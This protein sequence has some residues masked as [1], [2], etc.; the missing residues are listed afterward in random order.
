MNDNKFDDYVKR[1][2]GEKDS[3]RVDIIIPPKD[4]YVLLEHDKK[5]KIPFLHIILLLVTM[6]TTLVAG[7]LIENAPILS[8]FSSI[9]RGLPFSITLIS[10]LG[11][12]ELGHYTVSRMHGV[13]ATLP[14]FIPAPP[15]LFFIGTFGAFIK[16]KSPIYN[17][18]MLLD[19]GAAGPIAGFLIAVPSIVWGLQISEIKAV[20][21]GE[22]VLLGNSLLLYFLEKVLIGSVPAGYSVELSS[23]AFAGFIGLLV[24]AFNLM[25]IGQLDGGHI[26][27]ALFGK[28]QEIVAK[29]F[30]VLLVLMSFLW[31]GW[32]VW[33]ALV[34]IMKLR[35]PPT[36][37]DY[38][39]IDGRR[40]IVG[41]LCFVIFIL[42]FTP[43]PFSI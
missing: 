37:D 34:F 15:P 32:L 12:H 13:K 35:H 27:Y 6:F 4:E 3:K 41:Y 22:G 42:C 30:F 9:L 36:G 29:V 20:L 25:P 43:I 18:R 2:D 40:K 11:F 23:V 16:V 7:A 14:Y 5:N 28:K 8:D 39:Q 10:I 21:P 31:L 1:F 38:L 26:A 19:I 17:K 33:A 24:T